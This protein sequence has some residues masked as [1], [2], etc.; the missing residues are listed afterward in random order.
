MGAVHLGRVRG[1]EGFSRIVAIKCMHAE[2]SGDPAYVNMFLD[3]ARM[4]S[5]VRHVNV[6]PTLDVVSEGGSFWIVMEYVAG[7]SL[8]T[9]RRLGP[10]PPAIATAIFADVMT[11]LEAA[12]H[13][14]GPDGSPLELV[15]RDISPHNVLVG[16]DGVSRLADFGIARARNRSAVTRTGEFKGK[17][18]YAA[19]ELL[20]GE[21]AT[22][23][24]DVYSAGAALWEMLSG[25]PIF[26]G[27]TEAVL[28]FQVLESRPPPLSHVAPQVG[29]AFDAV[30]ERALAKE[31]E[32]RY[33]SARELREAVERCCPP[34]PARDVGAWLD[35]IA[36]DALRARADV[37]LQFEMG[38]SSNANA[39][40]LEE[41]S[42]ITSPS[43]P[44]GALP[45]T[46]LALSSSAPKRTRARSGV[47]AWAAA[48]L[49]TLVVL[50]SVTGLFAYAAARRAA[51]ESVEV[52]PLAATDQAPRDQAPEEP[53]P[54]IHAVSAP[55]PSPAE[56]SAAH[57]GATSA[58]PVQKPSP[59]KRPPPRA[60]RTPERVGPAASP[61]PCN[62]PYSID[63]FGDKQYKAECLR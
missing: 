25:R 8:S 5:R 58:D 39:V 30:L 54:A 48:G 45:K 61:A 59:P 26:T 32:A 62:P 28:L 56:A 42:T 1:I 53:A 47:L 33:G 22:V 11:G 57:A 31:P 63:E 29:V 37:V 23:R 43:V 36:G 41:A 16:A 6:V 38:R 51:P 2:V 46:P 14:A 9:L 18:I 19:P 17:L 55:A 20:N 15:H 7:A 13:A 34:A 3:E 50:G 60:A 44:A 4:A 10:V 40:Q 21:P 12:H 24:S 35:T 49:V 52:P 27:E